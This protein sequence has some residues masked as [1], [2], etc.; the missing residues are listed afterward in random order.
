MNSTA[1]S[2]IRAL[3]FKDN[4]PMR[5]LS[6]SGLNCLSRRNFSEGGASES[7]EWSFFAMS[8]QELISKH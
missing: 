1:K 6:F 7:H 4:Y 8:W 5:N 2:N 3:D